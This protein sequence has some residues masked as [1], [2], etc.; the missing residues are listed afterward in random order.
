MTEFILTEDSEGNVR[1]ISGG[2]DPDA[3]RAEV[4][5]AGLEVMGTA[6]SLT[7]A[8]LRKIAAS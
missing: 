1:V 8:E 7:R 3:V 4:E 2:G 5:A 6:Y